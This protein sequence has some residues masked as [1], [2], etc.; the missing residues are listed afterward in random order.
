M[1]LFQVGTK[2][3]QSS[4]KVTGYYPM[5]ELERVKARLQELKDSGEIFYFEV[6]V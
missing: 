5:T 6:M 2:E 3:T 4:A 1:Q